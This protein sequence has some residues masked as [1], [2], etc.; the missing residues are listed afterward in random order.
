MSL[1]DPELMSFAQSVPVFSQ[2]IAQSSA[3]LINSVDKTTQEH[4]DMKA[5]L[6]DNIQKFRVVLDQIETRIAD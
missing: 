6:K 3:Q 5:Y 4:T 2:A 1:P